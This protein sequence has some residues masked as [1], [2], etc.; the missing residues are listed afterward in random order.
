MAVEYKNDFLLY[1]I[2]SHYYEK[3]NLEG[4]SCLGISARL[5]KEKVASPKVWNH[6]GNLAQGSDFVNKMA[7]FTI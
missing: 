1:L 6:T 3:Q 4:N 5:G 7:K 2:H